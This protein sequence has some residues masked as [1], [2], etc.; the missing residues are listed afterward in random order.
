MVIFIL[1]QKIFFRLIEKNID[2]LIQAQLILRKIG[3]GAMARFL[4]TKICCKFNRTRHSVVL[5]KDHLN[6][7]NKL[8]T[9]Q[10]G[11]SPI[12]V[13]TLDGKPLRGNVNRFP[14]PAPAPIPVNP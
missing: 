10:S 1:I 4:P 7:P 11:S 5:I 2:W 3:L 12:S 8:T 14:L 13:G 6:D 9:P